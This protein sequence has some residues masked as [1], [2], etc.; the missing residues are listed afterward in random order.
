MQPVYRDADWKRA[1]ERVTRCKDTDELREFLRS[2]AFKMGTR[3]AEL[4]ASVGRRLPHASFWRK[5]DVKLVEQE[6]SHSGGH[7]ETDSLRMIFV[8]TSEN[9]FRKKFTAAH[10]A[11][12]LFLDQFLAQ[13]PES[14]SKSDEESLCDEFASALLIPPAKL[15]DIMK[16]YNDL[17]LE[18]VHSA[19]RA[20]QV[21]L[22]P[23]LIAIAQKDRF[24]HDVAFLAKRAGHPIRPREVEYRISRTPHR[25][26]VFLPPNKRLKSLG[27]GEIGDAL[28]DASPGAIRKGQ[29]NNATVPLWSRGRGSGTASGPLNWEAQLLSTGEILAIIHTHNLNQLWNPSKKQH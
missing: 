16:G 22:Q 8:R 15:E 14:L 12:H 24:P 28:H 17:T 6:S 3:I 20:L 10:E 21:N 11:A 2:E 25:G 29:A 26:V 5:L 4:E 13:H 1:Q 23:V 7:L 18:L 19:S 9:K 27:L